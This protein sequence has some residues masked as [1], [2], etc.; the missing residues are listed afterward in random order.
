MNE[1]KINYCDIPGA[2]I[3]KKVPTEIILDDDN[4]TIKFGSECK[5]YL[6]ENGLN[7]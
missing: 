5:K 3:D 2:D 4:K 1:N 6:Q 7:I